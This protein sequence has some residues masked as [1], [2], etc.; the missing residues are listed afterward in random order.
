MIENG[1][2]HLNKLSC[3]EEV[4]SALFL[5]KLRVC[6]EELVEIDQDTLVIEDFL[7]SPRAFE[8]YTLGILVILQRPLQ[9]LEK[10]GLII[11]DRDEVIP[12]HKNLTP[13]VHPMREGTECLEEQGV[14]AH[15][16]EHRVDVLIHPEIL[17]V[18][19]RLIGNS[20][21][22]P[23]QR[24]SGLRLARIRANCTT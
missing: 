12:R 5:E 18:E 13:R 8:C 15:P 2:L 4:S 9:L 7:R 16:I 17:V 22:P 1:V 23:P 3:H 6:V 24:L 11:V 20:L 10:V 21:R 14:P 19:V